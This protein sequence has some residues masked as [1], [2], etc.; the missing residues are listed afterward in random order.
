MVVTETVRVLVLGEGEDKVSPVARKM[1][2]NV[3]RSFKDMQAAAK[4]FQTGLRNITIAYGAVGAVVKKL[5]DTAAKAEGLEQAF[6][7]M[8]A[9]VGQDWKAV[10]SSI[11]EGSKGGISEMEA[12]QQANNALLLNVAKTPGEFELLTEA[13]RRLGSA[14]GV[15]AAYGMRSLVVGI[16]RQSR[17]WL[18]NLGIIVNVRKANE[19]YAASV[20]KAVDQLTD[21]ESMEAF[22]AATWEAI[23]QKMATLGEDT[24]ILSNKFGKYKAAWSDFT[25][26]LAK[27]ISPAVGEL[28]DYLSEIARDKE[29]LETGKR[30]G[31]MLIGFVKHLRELIPRILKIVEAVIRWAS[32]NKKLAVTMAFGYM[33]K[34]FIVASGQALVSIY[35]LIKA[36]KAL[37]AA[38]ATLN[39]TFALGAAAT[40]AMVAGIVAYGVELYHSVQ[41]WR[42][43]NDLTR[44]MGEASKEN[45]D[46]W[47]LAHEY[48]LAHAGEMKKLQPLI[49]EL[50]ELGGEWNK[51]LFQ[52]TTSLG[53][54]IDVL[55]E[56]IGKFKESTLSW[57]EV[58]PAE[59][60]AASIYEMNEQLVEALDKSFEEG[61]KEADEMFAK[62]KAA[63]DTIYAEIQAGLGEAI[64]AGGGE[65]LA[66]AL[67]DYSYESFFADFKSKMYN[68]TFSAI[69][70][71][72]AQEQI[73]SGFLDQIATAASQAITQFR[74]TGEINLTQLDQLF[75]QLAEDMQVMDPILQQ[76]S[77]LMG[78]H[79]ETVE[80]AKEATEAETRAI[81]EAEQLVW[82]YIDGQWQL[83]D[84]SA[85][86][87]DGFDMA[88]DAAGHFSEAAAQAA[89]NLPGTGTH[90]F[91]A[92]RYEPGSA[93]YRA[94][95]EAMERWYDFIRTGVSVGTNLPQLGAQHG[96]DRFFSGPE[97]GYT[98]PVEMHGRER[99]T[100][101]PEGGS[102]GG[103]KIEIHVDA[104]GA[105]G[106]SEDQMM[107]AAAR[108]IGPAWER[109]KRRGQGGRGN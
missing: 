69:I 17:L 28:A 101:T 48:G 14:M 106:I 94:Q 1:A 24:E 31:E 67:D 50:I 54:R 109:L 86:M 100:I 12:M 29:F 16:G 51:E 27:Q 83:I 45:A 96:M 40:V 8:T 84:A 34:G 76:L 60:M 70:E 33:F 82:R 41:H 68:A 26:M 47:K 32:E 79:T 75:V 66:A 92:A 18:D 104:R 108:K 62:I 91:T 53:E 35:K 87:R 103:G 98:V 73:F 42:E 22:K 107:E 81:E 44:T 89:A 13:A 71:A 97:T 65:A 99:M 49:A 61:M 30:I 80:M 36:T 93:E 37:T 4:S 72:L 59:A 15:D 102:V 9:S 95:Q 3:K 55:N 5:G 77:D 58:W 10:L 64:K 88:S 105:I 11:K 85:T 46:T 23:R 52:G 43:L 39:T 19:D 6:K 63:M 90:S 21:L 2:A 7:S 78:Q 20:G 56:K 25:K 38:S 57:E 74:E